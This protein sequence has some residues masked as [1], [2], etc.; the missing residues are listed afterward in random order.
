MN[1]KSFKV[2][3]IRAAI[4]GSAL[5]A[6]NGAAM[7]A[8]VSASLEFTCPF[9]LIGDQ[10]I[11]ANIN[12][13]YE[14]EY[15]IQEGQSTVTLPAVA[16]DAITI[17]PDRARQGLGFVNATTI[18][19]S[20]QSFNN[21]RTEAG[22]VIPNNTDLAITDTTIPVDESGPFDVPAGGVS[23]SQVFDLSDA[24]EVSLTVDDLI[25]NLKNLT[26]DGST[27][28]APVGEFIADCTLNPGQDNVLTTFNVVPT[29][30]VEPE[31]AITD[32]VSRSI[33]FGTNLLGV[34]ADA[35]TVTI[36]NSG[37][38]I[39][40]INAINISGSS[41]FSETNNCTTLE[42]GETCTATITYTASKEGVES[43]SV[44]INSTAGDASVELIGQGVD[45][46]KPIIKV[47]VTELDFSV[48]DEGTSAKQDIRIQNI[49]TAP[50]VISPVTVDGDQFE[51]TQNC[52][53]VAPTEACSETV[54]YNAVLG[55][56]TG[57]VDITSNADNA[58]QI[59]VSVSGTGKEVIVEPPTCDQ[60][61]NQAN[62]PIGPELVKVNLD[63]AGETFIAA[64]GGHVDLTGL[65]KS[66]IDITQGNFTGDLDLN[67][68]SGSFEIIKGW[69][70]YQ[71]TAN[72]EF[73]AVGGVTG[74]LVDGVLTAT[75]KAYVKLPKVT[76]TVF[77]L[78]NWKIGGGDEC[79]TKEPV[80]FTISSADGSVFN[81]LLGGEVVGSY[82]MPE[83][84]NCGALTS[85]LS[86]KLAGPG[87]TI[88]LELTPVFD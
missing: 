70:R 25:L 16:V 59:E 35:E 17:V 1:T 19:G 3:P 57:V 78:F 52:S 37:G 22:S 82:T 75:S 58:E 18:T 80:E 5:M 46:P 68:T 28:P 42:A 30:I 64:N 55:A 67:P 72:I 33:D 41:A 76:K 23:P 31:L 34:P 40:G 79:R 84:E 6:A 71:A 11:I 44:V 83:L 14:S 8:P 60:D 85:I 87:N 26:A 32:P 47:A 15:V 48:I 10:I 27:A 38:K 69:S 13:D 73:E 36:K 9:P 50:L 45:V 77:G 12:A 21:F 88:S 86:G 54:T 20:A 49:G 7:A 63:V 51:V 39:L 56:S 24:G 74:T 61:P 53:E 65:I 66:E 4:I 2:N 62:C 43:A 29:A 81:P